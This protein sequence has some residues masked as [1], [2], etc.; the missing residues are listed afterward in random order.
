MSSTNI[1]HWIDEIMTYVDRMG[2]LGEMDK[3][4]DDGACDRRYI[5]SV[6]EF[7]ETMVF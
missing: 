2:F 1:D 4:G 3:Y 6:Q 7:R 5:D